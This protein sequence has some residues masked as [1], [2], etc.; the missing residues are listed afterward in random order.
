M[1]VEAN[2]KQHIYE[3]CTNLDHLNIVFILIVTSDATHEK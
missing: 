3:V 1:H 2:E